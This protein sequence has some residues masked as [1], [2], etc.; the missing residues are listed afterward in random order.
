M[1]TDSFEST[2]PARMNLQF[3]CIPEHVSSQASV[4]FADRSLVVF[5]RLY[6]HCGAGKAGPTV[7]PINTICVLNSVPQQVKETGSYDPRCLILKIYGRNL[8][9]MW[10]KAMNQL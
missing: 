6:K 10:V 9:L 3:R 8:Y 5:A 2:A 7:H 1:H 4:R